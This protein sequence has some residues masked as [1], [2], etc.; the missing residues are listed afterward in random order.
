MV[1]QQYHFTVK[2]L[3]GEFEGWTALQPAPWAASVAG[4]AGGG[5]HGLVNVPLREAE[6]R[7]CAPRWPTSNSN[8]PG[9]LRRYARSTR[10]GRIQRSQA[11]LHAQQSVLT[12]IWPAR[13]IA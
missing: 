7:L 8:G 3:D 13:G 12:P 6:V 11:R 1:A 9:L 2:H 4:A 5:V 10:M